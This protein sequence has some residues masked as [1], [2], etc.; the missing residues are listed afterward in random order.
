MQDLTPQLRTRLGR[1]ERAVGLFVLL[2]T[3]L[4]LGGF[5]YY[6]YHTAKRKGW[7]D[8]KVTY[9]TELNNSAGLKV[10]D[11]VTLWGFNVGSITKIDTEPP[12]YIFNVYVE[13][14]VRA[15]YFGYLWTGG[16]VARVTAAD[17]L[18]KRSLEVTKGT[19]YCPTHLLWPVREFTVAEALKLPD[20]TNQLF[21]DGIPGSGTNPPLTT[22]LQSA[23]PATL[24]K[25]AAAH[26]TAVRLANRAVQQETP[27]MVWNFIS[28]RYQ[29]YF[30]DKHV[31]GVN[32]YWLPPEESPA[33]TERLDGLINNAGQ[34][35]SQQLPMLLSN[36]VSL[37][38]NANQ[39]LAETQPLLANLTLVT[40]NLTN[41]NGSLG[42][43]LL[44]TNLHAQ[45]LLTLTNAD[46]TLA[47]ASLAL[48][49]ASQ[50][51]LS[52]NSNLTA[53]VTQLQPP[54]DNL[55]TII[56]NM[57]LQVQANTNFMATLS[58]LLKDTD[59]LIE[60]LKRHWLFRSAFKVKPTNAPAKKRR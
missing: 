8:T 29:A 38:S 23:D 33:L 35:I 3:L 56:S 11:P 1:V 7:F 50:M 27:T 9:Y 13:F 39:V 4:L 44:P 46:G 58:A 53:L 42:Q 55:A 34:T 18:G 17:F 49:N 19:N 47:N 24:Q 57:N 32:P 54:L 30:P 2:A 5:G 40:A 15:P 14:T 22:V 41:A 36:T 6:V 59:N 52:A 25:I 20:L 31:P 51:M 37:T 45:L 60:G 26:I 21:L 10:G 43:W 12:D 16:S 48:T 28:N